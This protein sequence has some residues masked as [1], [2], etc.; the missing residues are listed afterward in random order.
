MASV[1]STSQLDDDD[2]DNNGHEQEGGEGEK[3]EHGAGHD[4]G[5][6]GSES[7]WSLVNSEGGEEEQVAGKGSKKTSGP[8]A[9]E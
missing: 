9:A 8:A 7:D 6:G 5:D 4:E 1:M 2:D 3:G